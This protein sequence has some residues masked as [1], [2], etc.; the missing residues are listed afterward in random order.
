MAADRHSTR[1][2]VPHTQWRSSD[3]LDHSR[4]VNECRSV[5]DARGILGPGQVQTARAMDVF[6]VFL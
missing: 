5:F 6:A 2:T 4:L 1:L 3:E